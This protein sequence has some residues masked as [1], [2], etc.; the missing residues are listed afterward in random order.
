MLEQT[1]AR[2]EVLRATVDELHRM[3]DEIAGGYVTA[4]PQ[5]MFER[6][7]AALE[8]QPVEAEITIIGEAVIE[9][10]APGDELEAEP[11]EWEP[12]A[13]D[14]VEATEEEEAPVKVPEEDLAAADQDESMPEPDVKVPSLPVSEQLGE[15]A[16]ELERPA[17]PELRDLTELVQRPVAETPVRA[18]EPARVDPTLLE[19]LLNNAGEVSIFHSRL[20][21]QM[22]QIQFNLEELGQT[23]IRLRGQLRGLEMATEA[24]IIYQHQVDQRSGEE[25]DPLTLER[26]SKIQQLSRSLAETASDV[27]SLKDLLQN[28]VGDT[29]ALL[30]QQARTAVELQDGLMR[31]RMV[32]FQQQGNAPV[33]TRPADSLRARQACRAI[34]ARW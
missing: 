13:A 25:V 22:S 32:G 4:P 29:E 31:T 8:D 24:Q 19:N 10:A 5:A 26:Y 27:S 18:R 20:T 33:Q 1:E 2:F 28:L 14:F 34:V 17:V 9:G 15:L 30:V 12:V 11:V 21:Q 23:V 3:R 16:R 7:D 6:L